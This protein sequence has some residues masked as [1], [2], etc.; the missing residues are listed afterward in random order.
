MNRIPVKL[1]T[2][3]AARRFGTSHQ[4]ETS[5]SPR[6]IPISDIRRVARDLADERSPPPPRLS[7]LPEIFDPNSMQFNPLQAAVLTHSFIRSGNLKK[8]HWYIHEIAK[9][10]QLKNRAFPFKSRT[11]GSLL[12]ALVDDHHSSPAPSRLG[13]TDESLSDWE[14]QEDPHVASTSSLSG[15][16]QDALLLLESLRQAG[17]PRTEG[18]YQKL[19]SALLERDFFSEAVSIYA[20]LAID[21]SGYRAK[22]IKDKRRRDKLVSRTVRCQNMLTPELDKWDLLDILP[23]SLIRSPT[24]PPLPSEKLL[25]PIVSH[26]AKR[27]DQELPDQHMTS[28]AEIIDPST[29]PGLFSAYDGVR[30][31][32]TLLYHK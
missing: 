21:W 14:G 1:R 15:H 5:G 24:L 29:A 8:A 31:L 12:D 27:L 16:L 18:M 10:V 6:K 32:S 26:I 4:W 13:A 11:V 19:M 3:Y 9:P 28:S 22:C 2:S 25:H 23:Q 20:G 17:L 7:S 30:I